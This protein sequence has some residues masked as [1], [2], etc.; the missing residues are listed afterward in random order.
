MMRVHRPQPIVEQVNSILRQRIHTQHYPPG[1]RLPSESELA[2]ELGV[3]RATVRTVLAKFAV[4]GLVL[5]KQGDGTYV[6]ER[7]R[8]VDARYGGMWDFSRLIESNGYQPSIHT[9][10]IEERSATEIEAAKLSLTPEQP[11]LSLVRLF[12]ANERPS[13]LAINI[14]PRYLLETEIHQVNAQLPIHKILQEYCHQ[15]IAYAISD[16]EATVGEAEL[17]HVLERPA[18]SPLLKLKETFYNKDNQPLVYGV[19]YYDHTILRLRL[20]QAWG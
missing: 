18:G 12:R 6:N 9:L 13:I 4:E 16:I 3:S 10:S 15:R 7:I 20:V 17:T 1:G 5:R 11:V 19:S 8:E 2:Q 14:I